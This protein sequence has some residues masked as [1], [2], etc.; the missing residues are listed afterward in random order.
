MVVFE[1]RNV[2]GEMVGEPGQVSIALVDPSQSG[3]QARLARWDFAPQD[4]F[5]QFHRSGANGR[6]YAFELPWPAAAPA[7]KN[8]Q[9]FVR[10]VTPDGR[11]LMS[12]MTLNV[13]PPGNR[14][15]QRWRTSSAAPDRDDSSEPGPLRRLL[16]RSTSE[17]GGA[18]SEAPRFAGSTAGANETAEL[19]SIQTD[20]DEEDDEEVEHPAARKRR[21]TLTARRADDDRPSWSPYR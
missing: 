14:Q 19:P 13:D 18:D 6:G 5:S 10:Y 7:N 12:D 4:A 20:E 16:S 8:L 15:A 3:P 17:R 1:P 9:L 11:K 21:P 2:R